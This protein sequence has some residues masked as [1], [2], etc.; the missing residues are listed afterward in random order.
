MTGRNRS[1]GWTHAK[2]SGHEMEDYISERL[3]IDRSFSSSLHKRCFGHP[4][5]KPPSVDSGGISAIHVP[6]VLGGSTQRKTDISIKWPNGQSARISL[7]KSCGGQVWLI[8]TSRFFSS[9]EK[10]YG[11]TIPDIIKTG[12]NMFI[13]SDLKGTIE[14]LLDG[15]QPV[16]PRRKKDGQYLEIHQQRLVAETLERYF[17]KEWQGV[18]AWMRTNLPK[19]FQLCFSRGLCSNPE[20]WADFAWYYVI[21]EDSP[22]RAMILDELYRVDDISRK[23]DKMDLKDRVVVGPRSG[24]STLIL[25]FGFLQMHSPIGKNQMQ[26]HH[27]R[28]KLM[29]LSNRE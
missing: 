27:S 2:L 16:G 24:G 6:S 18:I 4:C 12:M 20:D 3:L 29:S 15:R 25:P 7:K 8:T 1:E 9:F 19:I 14:S 5:D 21:D 17:S 10:H 26:F 13:G 11:E 23:I 28:S 22:K